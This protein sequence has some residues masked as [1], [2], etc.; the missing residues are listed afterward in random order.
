MNPPLSPRLP[1]EML[2]NIG[3][4]HFLTVDSR[5]DQRGIKQLSGRSDE[6]FAVEILLIPRL[7]TDQHDLGR[8]LALA[9]Y[10]LR[11]LPPEVAGS[12]I[13][14]GGLQLADCGFPREQFGGGM[15]VPWAL[16]EI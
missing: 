7:L 14:S 1:L 16:H 5:F 6:G 10:R 13:A 11:S 15:F 3:D 12:A 4:I 2:H 8:G 9:E